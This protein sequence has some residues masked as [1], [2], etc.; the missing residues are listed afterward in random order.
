MRKG[1]VVLLAG[2]GYILTSAP[3]WGQFA[4]DKWE[5]TP[6]V[7]YETSGSYAVNPN[8]TT[9]PVNNLQVNG[10]ASF[11]TFIDYSI[12]PDAQFEFMWD[13]NLTSY[14]EQQFPNPAYVKAYNSSVDQY[15]FGALYMIFGEE[16]KWR[17]YV[18]GSVGFTHEF[19]SALSATTPSPPTRL[20]FS[21]SLGGGVKYELS[22]HLAF[23]GDARYMPTYANSSLAEYCDPF[24]GCYTAKVSNYQHRGNFLVGLVIRF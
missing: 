9:I 12:T 20:D 15:Q 5:V 13:R 18:A 22:R 8:S 7:G 19:N 2:L 14:S 10:A 17:P 3:A 11:G 16:H 6:F 21:Y 24:Y 1:M 4:P 23:R